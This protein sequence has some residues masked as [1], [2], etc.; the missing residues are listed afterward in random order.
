MVTNPFRRRKHKEEEVKIDVARDYERA[1]EVHTKSG[2]DVIVFSESIE[3]ER[4]RGLLALDVQIARPGVDTPEGAEYRIAVYKTLGDRKIILPGSI[5]VGKNG[6]SV[7]GLK[8]IP[9]EDGS[10]E[11]RAEL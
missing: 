7:K 5:Y 6:I 9:S 10:L 1:R 3:I 4:K 2:L 11:Y 8:L